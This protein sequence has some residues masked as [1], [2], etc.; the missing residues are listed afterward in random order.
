MK[1]HV[2]RAS[3]WEEEVLARSMA[4]SIAYAFDTKCRLVPISPAPASSSNMGSPHGSLLDLDGTGY[5]ASTMEEKINEIFVNTTPQLT[6]FSRCKSVWIETKDQRIQSDYKYKSELHN[7]EGKTKN[8]AL[9]LRGDTAR[10][11]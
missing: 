11:Q 7:P 1:K 4:C 2:V 3:D 10:H 8:L 5:H 6:H 9:R